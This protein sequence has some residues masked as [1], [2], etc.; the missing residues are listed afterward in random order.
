MHLVRT[1]NVA[2]EAALGAG[3]PATVPAYTI[4]Q[5]CIS[6][7]RAICSGAE[8]ILSNQGDIFLCGGCE[9]FSDVPIRF[10]RPLRKRFLK[11]NKALKKGPLQALSLFRGVR[12]RDLAPEPPAIKNF[13]TNEVM[14][15]S[16]DRLAARFGVSREDQD[17][18]AAR[19]HQNA[20]KAHEQGYYKQEIIPVKGD[21]TE[22]GIR[23]DST[24]ESLSKLKPAFIKPHGTHTA[25]NSSFLTDGAAA[26]LLMERSTATAMDIKIKSII[27]DFVFV[28]VDPFDSMLL[29]PAHA[30]QKLLQRSKNVLGTELKLDDV[31]VLE[32]HEAFAGQVL[33]NVVQMK[34]NGLEVDMSKVNKWGGS[35]SI[36]HPFGATG[37]RLV[38]TASNR[39]IKED[40]QFAIVA[41]CADGGI[42]HACLLER[43]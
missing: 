43:A 28:A 7:N 10:S 22:N 8:K 15:H 38:T 39:L 37:A 2:R 41:A 6:S 25:A 1:S 32:I 31:D 17:A 3:I 19:S 13:S 14:G 30:V 42:G 27:R 35:L 20:A 34:Q 23:G 4:S 18:F 26:V 9:T 40:K 5:A 11:L 29:G 12:M 21:V 24:S 36:G 16:S 33:A